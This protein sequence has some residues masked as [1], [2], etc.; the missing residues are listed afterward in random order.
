[1]KSTKAMAEGKV[2][3]AQAAIGP[4][5]LFTSFFVSPVSSFINTPISLNAYRSMPGNRHRTGIA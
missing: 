4:H 5:A 1:M 2:N 3:S